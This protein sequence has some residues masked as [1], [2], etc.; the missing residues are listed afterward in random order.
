MAEKDLSDDG[1]VVQKV[2]HSVLLQSNVIDGFLQASD[3]LMQKHACDILVNFAL[4][5]F[6]APVV[7]QLNPCG[8]LV[9]LLR[10]S[11]Q[12]LTARALDALYCIADR[13]NGGQAIISAGTLKLL[14]ELL[15]SSYA[16]VRTTVCLVLS[17]L[18]FHKSILDSVI[19]TKSSRALVS[20]LRDKNPEVGK[21]AAMV[22][23]WIARCAEGAKTVVEAQMPDLL[24]AVLN[25]PDPWETCWVLQ[26][27]AAHNSTTGIMSSAH[28][29]QHIVGLLR[30]DA[31]VRD[32]LSALVSIARSVQG[33]RAVFDTGILDFL[34]EFLESADGH[35][36]KQ[37]CH[38]LRNLAIHEFAI[39]AL[40]ENN[41]CRK[42]IHL[43]RDDAPGVATSAL[44]A[45][46]QIISH[47]D[48]AVAMIDAGALGALDELLRFS[49]GELRRETWD[50]IDVL[51]D[52]QVVLAGGAIIV[53]QQLRCCLN[54]Q[55]RNE[56]CDLFRI[57]ALK[58]STADAA[59]RGNPF[60]RLVSLLPVEPAAAA[61]LDPLDFIAC[62]E[63]PARAVRVAARIQ[64]LLW[65]RIMHPQTEIGR[66]PGEII[67]DEQ[68][69]TGCEDA[70]Y[71]EGDR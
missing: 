30:R 9:S 1:P 11:N 51:A 12:I 6:S 8:R 52:N 26:N 55:I 47:E 50:L 10:G 69:W 39:S 32:A 43:L 71:E 22:L 60:Q 54:D 67:F 33:A 64:F 18:A 17:R 25:L 66:Q 53:I 57:M 70:I 36:R 38:L 48:G 21:H 35:V 49:N 37:T 68:I 46:S 63:Y 61:A 15:S 13:V 31:A 7:L 56:A 24:D 44:G 41:R 34:N 59:V 23:G 5:K 19:H 40:L 20:L 14:D 45:L 3:P 65:F 2:A 58:D 42:L 62:S 28:I 16:K 4:N 27:L 29:C